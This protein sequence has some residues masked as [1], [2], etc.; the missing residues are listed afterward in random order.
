L[1]LQID[2]T[3]DQETDLVQTFD[4]SFYLVSIVGW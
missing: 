1:L 3:A 2:K 4:T